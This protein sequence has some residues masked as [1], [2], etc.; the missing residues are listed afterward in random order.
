MRRYF[1]IFGR[2]RREL[3][4]SLW[5]VLAGSLLWG[6]FCPTRSYGFDEPNWN[7]APS[8]LMQEGGMVII[9]LTGLF[10]AINAYRAQ[11]NTSEER[12]LI[13]LWVAVICFWIF[14]RMTS[15]LYWWGRIPS[16]HKP[17]WLT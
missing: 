15:V 11:E 9:A 7:V 14:L 2:N 13:V 4:T 17:G 12:T 8:H 6:I 1:Q 16:L 3:R 5:I 10:C